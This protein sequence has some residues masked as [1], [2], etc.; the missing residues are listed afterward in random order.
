MQTCVYA[1]DNTIYLPSCFILITLI[2]FPSQTP[3]NFFFSLWQCFCYFIW[4]FSCAFRCLC[5]CMHSSNSVTHRRSD[6]RSKSV[7]EIF[8]LSSLIPS[9]R[10]CNRETML[11]FWGL[12]WWICISNF[13]L[14]SEFNK[15]LKE[16]L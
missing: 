10:Q 8:S 5:V 2:L 14:F 6:F 3:E 13:P 16:Q 11:C 7:N 1:C 15:I 12:L 9:A 4:Y